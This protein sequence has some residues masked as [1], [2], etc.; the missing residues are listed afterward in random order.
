MTDRNPPG[1][2]APREAPPLDRPNELRTDRLLLRPFELTDVDDVFAYAADPE[3]GRFLP[4]PQPYLRRN[5][6]EFVARSILASWETGP[7][8]AIVFD[9]TVNGGIGLRIDVQHE[10]G[11]I[12]YS[13]A[14][15]HWG[16][17]LMLEACR[18]VIE[19]G[20]AQRSLAKLLVRV[21]SRNTRSLRV[22]EKLGMTQEGVLRSH[23]KVGDGRADFVY[24][25]LLR[26]E[27]MERAME[28][29]ADVRR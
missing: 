17:G 15:P 11:E 9:G 16:E 18:A 20:F 24:Y 6:E 21:D 4:L 26:E 7:L 19:W 14:R 29:S 12:G 1:V 13:L 22:A 8:W 10:L 25:G 28:A 23:V 27:W 2:G 3:W 5:A